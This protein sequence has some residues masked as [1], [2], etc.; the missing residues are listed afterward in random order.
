[1]CVCVLGICISWR[2]KSIKKWKLEGSVP[3]PTAHRPGMILKS[4][5]VTTFPSNHDKP[6]FHDKILKIGGD[7]NRKNLKAVES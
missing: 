1:M 4:G 6:A 2:I 3:I 7:E 5:G